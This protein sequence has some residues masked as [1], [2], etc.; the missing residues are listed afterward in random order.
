MRFIFV[1]IIIPGNS[2]A[3]D[4][5]GRRRGPLVPPAPSLQIQVPDNWG[6]L[7][8]H[9]DPEIEGWRVLTYKEVR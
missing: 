2:L 9:Y 1:E 4:H 6:L 3:L 5:Q 7:A 8:Y